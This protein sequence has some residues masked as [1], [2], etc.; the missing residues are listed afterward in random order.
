MKILL[1]CKIIVF[2]MHRE[3][4]VL[5]ELSL[6]PFAYKILYTTVEFRGDIALTGRCLEMKVVKNLPQ[7]SLEKGN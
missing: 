2:A 1:R 4:A 3:V 5:N 7:T 6:A